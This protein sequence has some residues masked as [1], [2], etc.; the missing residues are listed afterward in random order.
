M[1]RD[2]GDSAAYGA[3]ASS[4]KTSAARGHARGLV[5][6]EGSLHR[7]GVRVGTHHRLCGGEGVGG[8]ARAGAVV[9]RR[10]G[11]R[12]RLIA[13]ARRRDRAAQSVAVELRVE[14]VFSSR[15]LAEHL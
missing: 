14:R 15:R 5:V 12:R 4:A 8:L 1:K 13:A 9:A 6:Q 7:P 10:P 11:A 2:C 3:L